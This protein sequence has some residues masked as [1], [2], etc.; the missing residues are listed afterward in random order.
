VAVLFLIFSRFHLFSISLLSELKPG[1]IDGQRQLSPSSI[2][3]LMC[4]M[5]WHALHPLIFSA[6]LELG[7]QSAEIEHFSL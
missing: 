3:Y 4:L 1:H 5:V 6:R 2:D 7:G